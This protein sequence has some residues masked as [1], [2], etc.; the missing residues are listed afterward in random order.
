MHIGMDDPSVNLLFERK[1]NILYEFFSL[2]TCSLHPNHT[3]FRK[4][5]TGNGFSTLLI[6]S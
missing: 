5:L 6:F 2:G 4:R 3:T 1:L